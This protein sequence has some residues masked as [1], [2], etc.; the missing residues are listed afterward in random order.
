MLFDGWLPF[1]C[2]LSLITGID[3]VIISISRVIDWHNRFPTG[4]SFTPLSR[5]WV[6]LMNYRE[7][8][9]EFNGSQQTELCK[10]IINILLDSSCSAKC[11]YRRSGVSRLAQQKI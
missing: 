8:R 3:N 9:N 7:K 6:C 10:M 5:S 1:T 2:N 4:W 11:L